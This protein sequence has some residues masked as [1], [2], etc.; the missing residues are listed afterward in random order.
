MNCWEFIKC[1]QEYREYCL[2]YP[3]YGKICWK[4]TLISCKS[5][6]VLDQNTKIEE[7]L[8]CEF[9]KMYKAEYK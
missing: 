2:A 8:Q 6:K 3:N 7:C 1:P 4:A 5:G 9:Y